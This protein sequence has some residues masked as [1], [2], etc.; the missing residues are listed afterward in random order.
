[1]LYAYSVRLRFIEKERWNLYL[2]FKNKR[3]V[4]RGINNAVPLL[5]QLFL[6]QC[7]DTLNCPKDY[8]QVFK[9]S[10]YDGMQK[11][12]HVQE[13]PEYTKEYLFKTDTPLFVGK[14]FAIDDGEHSTMLLAEEY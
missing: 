9:C 10:M 13:Q 4:T 8:L 2:K 5:T 14:I 11:I 12:I 1:M 7:I 6:W 3:Y